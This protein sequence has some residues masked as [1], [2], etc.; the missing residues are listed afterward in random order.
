MS[1]WWCGFEPV[2]Q[3]LEPSVSVWLD[4]SS[5]PSWV[6]SG[7]PGS[8]ALPAMPAGPCR[9]LLPTRTG[10]T[11]L[12][13]ELLLA[14]TRT[15]A[16][17]VA[18]RCPASSPNPSA[19]A[20]GALAPWLGRCVVRTDSQETRGKWPWPPPDISASSCKHGQIGSPS[21]LR[22]HAR[23]PDPDHHHLPEAPCFPW[24]PPHPGSPTQD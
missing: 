10:G 22:G 9:A 12:A 13:A 21:A 6:C 8:E 18:G 23:V 7:C 20:G 17:P 14:H 16:G 19:L 1:G 11:L 3:A 15:H 5:G 24:E 4:A 2:R